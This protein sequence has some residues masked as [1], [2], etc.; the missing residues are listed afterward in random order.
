MGSLKT[1]DWNFS[2][3]KNFKV[4]SKKKQHS[5]FDHSQFDDEFEGEEYPQL[6]RYKKQDY[7][8]AKRKDFKGDF[9]QA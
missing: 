3:E 5:N 8:I 6:N 1:Q 2:K 4:R 9:D 7:R